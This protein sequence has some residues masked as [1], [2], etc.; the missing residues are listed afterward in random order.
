MHGNMWLTMVK[1]GV[2]KKAT[3]EGMIEKWWCFVLAVIFFPIFCLAVYIIILISLYIAMDWS[4]GFAA[5]HFDLQGFV[6]LVYRN[7][8]LTLFFSL[9]TSMVHSSKQKAVY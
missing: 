2:V 8:S 7:L 5:T 9:S 1:S 3:E 6:L 4:L